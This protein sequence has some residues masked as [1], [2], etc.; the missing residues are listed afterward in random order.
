MAL[1]TKSDAVIGLLNA[2]LRAQRRCPP[3]FKKTEITLIN[4]AL[5]TLG[6]DESEKRAV[7][8]RLELE[9]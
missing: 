3:H 6:L 8:I 9:V 4:R 5:T 2:D 7:L 1:L